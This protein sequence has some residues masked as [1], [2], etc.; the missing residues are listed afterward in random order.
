[1]SKI[2]KICLIDQT[3]IKKTFIFNGSNE[4]TFSKESETTLSV[5]TYIH[6]DDSIRR[7]KEKLF[8]HCD[9]NISISE[10]RYLL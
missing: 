9:L 7:I 10:S 6:K 4:E 3:R 1:M 8:L 5:N 2:F